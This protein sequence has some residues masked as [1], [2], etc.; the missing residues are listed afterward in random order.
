MSA[1]IESLAERSVARGCGFAALAIFT[2]MVGLSWDGAVACE[3][4]CLLM[5]LVCAIL[6]LKAWRAPYRPFRRTE[7]WMMLDR[8]QRPSPAVAQRVIGGM[9]R[10]C[11]MQFA[12]HAAG[13]SAA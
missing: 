13:L 9:L 4:G 11:Y 8:R 7:L 6:L 12:L 3:I 2:L 10:G 5:L 1:N